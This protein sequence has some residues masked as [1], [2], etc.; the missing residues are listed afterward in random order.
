MQHFA[1]GSPCHAAS[2]SSSSPLASVPAAVSSKVEQLAARIRTRLQRAE[3]ANVT[4]QT[5][6]HRPPLAAWSEIELGLN[7]DVFERDY[8]TPTQ[9]ISSVRSWRCCRC[10]CGRWSVHFQGFLGSVLCVH[11]HGECVCQS[12]AGASRLGSCTRSNSESCEGCPLAVCRS[13]PRIP[14]VAGALADFISSSSTRVFDRPLWT[15]FRASLHKVCFSLLSHLF[16]T[17]WLRRPN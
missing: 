15:P 12:R 13:C 16:I 11:L 3:E 9:P 6:G 5:S 4:L 7:L 17:Y 14:V 2:Q 10:H 1:T 8:L